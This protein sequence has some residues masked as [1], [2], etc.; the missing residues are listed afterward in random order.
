VY[1]PEVD[2]VENEDLWLE[3][4]KRTA[5]WPA[6]AA[7]AIAWD[8]WLSLNLYSRQP[9]LGLILPAITKEGQH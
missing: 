3:V 4:V 7:A 1:D 5:P 8:A 6:V 2:E 9:W